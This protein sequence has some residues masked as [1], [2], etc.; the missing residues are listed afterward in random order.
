MHIAA[1][2]RL[3]SSFG[4]VGRRD[5]PWD[6]F[7]RLRCASKSCFP[8]ISGLLVNCDGDRCDECGI[9]RESEALVE[10]R[11][12]AVLKKTSRK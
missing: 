12:V 9:C 7:R 5:L 4:Y 1:D 6:R 8:L 11:S 2:S 3:E 10:S